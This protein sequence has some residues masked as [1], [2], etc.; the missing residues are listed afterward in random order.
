MLS[1]PALAKLPPVSG[2][3]LLIVLVDHDINRAGQS[4]ALR[5]TE[6]WN[7]GGAERGIN[8]A[9]PGSTAGGDIAS[10]CPQ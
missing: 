7:R 5:C 9:E 1:A 4:A 2:V 6:R 8:S 3:K 10:P